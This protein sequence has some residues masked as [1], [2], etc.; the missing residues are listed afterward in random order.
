MGDLEEK[1]G[2]SRIPTTTPDEAA[3]VIVDGIESDDY[4]VYV[5]VDAKVMSLANKLAPRRAAQ[6]V[7]NQMKD[8]LDTKPES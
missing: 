2:T 4:H 5:G 7:R 1:A 8:L 6:L 3:T